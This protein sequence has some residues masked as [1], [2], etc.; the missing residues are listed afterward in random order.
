MEQ[1]DSGRM[2]LERLRR[3]DST[4]AIPVI[5][6][7]ADGV[8]VHEQRQWLQGHGIPVLDKPFDLDV[9]LA[10]VAAQLGGTPTTT[11]AGSA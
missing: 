2:L 1:P 3:D 11:G 4:A 8:Q 6:C 7:S 10:L 9:F 5:V